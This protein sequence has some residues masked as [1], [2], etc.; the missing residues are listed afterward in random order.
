MGI[1]ELMLDDDGIN[2]RDN[3]FLFGCKP[4]ANNFKRGS[5]QRRFG[6]DTSSDEEERRT[7]IYKR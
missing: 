1:N 4:S 2:N 6:G 5:Q 3:N 7:S